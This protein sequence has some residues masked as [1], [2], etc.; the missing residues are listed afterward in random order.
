MRRI[1]LALCAL[2]IHV[3]AQSQISHNVG[4]IVMIE[5]SL[6][7]HFVGSSAA[8]NFIKRY[9]AT[10]DFQSFAIDTTLVLL[11]Q[12]FPK[13]DFCTMESDNFLVYE[14]N[15][16]TLRATLFRDFRE[17]WFNSLKEKYDVDAILVIRNS[18]RFTDGIHWSNTDITGYGIYNGPRRANNYVYIQLEFLFFDSGRPLTYIQGPIFQGDKDYPRRDKLAELFDESDLLLAEP[19]LK[20]LIINQIEAAISNANL[21]RQ[22]R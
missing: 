8:N 16:E 18:S 17:T 20:Q 14:E 5:D 1:I 15:R 7:H 22:L 21:L 3:S 13:W 10:T 11:E 6:T 9:P 19:P 2:M 12:N 4:L